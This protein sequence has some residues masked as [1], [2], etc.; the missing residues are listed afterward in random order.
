ML[1]EESSGFGSSPSPWKDTQQ[2]VW[3]VTLTR[4]ELGKG[5]KNFVDH[6]GEKW[7][8]SLTE[9]KM[10]F[11]K[12]KMKTVLICSLEQKYKSRSE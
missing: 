2:R 10:F 4:S 11:I 12:S 1:Q 7:E 5:E 9:S 8:G 3:L 6:E